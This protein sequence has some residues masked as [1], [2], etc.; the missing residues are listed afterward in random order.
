MAAIITISQPTG[1]GAG[2]PGFARKGLWVGQAVQLIDA[3]R[4]SG[5]LRRADE[6]E[7]ERVKQ[8]NEPFALVVGELDVLAQRVEIFGRR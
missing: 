4:K 7:I 1:A 3:V 8:Q 5:Q 2:L 6:R